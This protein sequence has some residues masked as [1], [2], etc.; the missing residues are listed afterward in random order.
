M[1]QLISRMLARKNTVLFL[2][3]L[4]ALPFLIR[5]PDLRLVENVDYFANENHRDVIFYKELKSI[6]GNDEFF[7]VAFK[8]Q[9]LW[10]SELSRGR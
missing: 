6:F 1:A 9:N 10:L 7:I 2:S 4:I 3:V 8:K 5:I